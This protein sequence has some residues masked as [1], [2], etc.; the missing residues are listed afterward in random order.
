MSHKDKDRGLY[1]YQVLI[2]LLEA[3]LGH[4]MAV[5]VIRQYC[6]ELG[7]K[8]TDLNDSHLETIAMR[9]NTALESFVDPDQITYIVQQIILLKEYDDWGTI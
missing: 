5:Q 2:S 4:H 6:N 8:E 3:D 9:L 1:Y 7:V